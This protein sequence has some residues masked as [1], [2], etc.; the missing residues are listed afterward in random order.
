MKKLLLLITIICSSVS[1]SQKEEILEYS[2]VKALEKHSTE[3]S[4]DTLSYQKPEL[5]TF[6]IVAEH[7]VEKQKET[8]KKYIVR[9]TDTL[10]KI[11]KRY[12]MY[13][14]MEGRKNDFLVVKTVKF[15]LNKK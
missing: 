6:F 14:L 10:K 3:I 8:V 4:T 15:K 2:D 1:Y 5:K 7:R 12:E 9:N 13:D 11:Q